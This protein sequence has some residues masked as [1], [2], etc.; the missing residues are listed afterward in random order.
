MEHEGTDE[1]ESAPHGPHSSVHHGF[2]SIV[3][4][5]L[6]AP[7]W[8][9]PHFAVAVPFHIPISCSVLVEGSLPEGSSLV[10]ASEKSASVLALGTPYAIPKTAGDG[11]MRLV[12]VDRAAID[13][14][15]ADAL[16]QVASKGAPCAAAFRPVRMHPSWETGDEVRYVY[17]LETA[18]PS[19]CSASFV[20]TDYLDR[21][22]PVPRAEGAK[23]RPAPTTPGPSP[24]PSSSSPTTSG[25]SSE[26]PRAGGCAV[27]VGDG[28]A[29]AA[30]LTLACAAVLAMLR[31]ASGRSRRRRASRL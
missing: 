9:S 12:L 20:R 27:G 16:A 24:S 31:R 3:R 7:V 30:A 8:S 21:G 17:R 25:P 6:V 26:A 10:L 14:E 19:A 5:G 13:D 29:R 18:S 23:L 4:V 28:A 11:P 22:N 2:A 15:S 1:G